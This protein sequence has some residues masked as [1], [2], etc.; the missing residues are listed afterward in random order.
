MGKRKVA[1]YK[2]TSFYNGY[3]YRYELEVRVNLDDSDAF[4]LCT[5]RDT[6]LAKVIE[7]YII[8]KKYLWTGDKRLRKR[9]TDRDWLLL[10]AFKEA[11][12]KYSA[13]Y[14]KALDTKMKVEDLEAQIFWRVL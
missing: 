5:G 3:G 13:L 12:P 2:K 1:E 6:A 4:F 11:G 10:K 9:L 7:K 8:R 14:F